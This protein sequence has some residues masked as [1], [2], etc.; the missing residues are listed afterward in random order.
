MKVV[1]YEIQKQI[2]AFLEYFIDI[3]IFQFKYGKIMV[4]FSQNIFQLT[5]L[6]DSE[7]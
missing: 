6:K 4:Q 3:F 2:R 7:K 1:F 5:N